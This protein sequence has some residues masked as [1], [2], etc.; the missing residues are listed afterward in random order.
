MKNLSFVSVI[1]LSAG[2]FICG[3]GSSEDAPPSDQDLMQGAWAGAAAGMEAEFTMTVSGDNFDMRMTGGEIW[4][5][6]TFVLNDKVTP[7]QAD[8][9]ITESNFEEYVGTTAKAIYKIENDTLTVASNEPG[10][11]TVPASFEQTGEAQVF[12]LKKK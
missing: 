7:K 4:Y 1:L 6:G 8:F 12:T 10:S 9:K 2:I 11:G 5:K 3:C